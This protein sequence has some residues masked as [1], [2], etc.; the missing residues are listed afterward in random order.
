[1]RSPTQPGIALGT[2]ISDHPQSVVGSRG[3]RIQSYV[4]LGIGTVLLLAGLGAFVIMAEAA[5]QN[6]LICLGFAGFC[7]LGIGMLGVLDA[8]KTRDMSL[9]LYEHGLHYVDK[10]GEKIWAW[11]QI[12][13]ISEHRAI[14]QQTKMVRCSYQLVD[15]HGDTLLLYD[16]I[17]NPAAAIAT[18]RQKTYALLLPKI[19]AAVAAGQPVSFGVITMTSAGLE[20]KGRTIAWIEIAGI[21]VSGTLMMIDR[22]GG[23]WFDDLEL[24]LGEVANFELL[25]Q[26]SAR[27]F[28]PAN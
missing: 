1:M 28:T 26:L 10:Y 6:A 13:S 15:H 18:I 16:H 9:S 7:V 17:R 12:E 2:L 20:V 25:Q 23:G 3:R 8:R 4:A 19:S 5:G 24:N 22:H 21:Q 11:N 14:N 27:R